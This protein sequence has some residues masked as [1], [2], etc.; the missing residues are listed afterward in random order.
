MAGE[1]GEPS[2]NYLNPAAENRLLASKVTMTIRE[3]D[4]FR[5]EV[6]GAGGW[7]D[8]LER[9][10]WRVAKDVRN[11]FVS[12]EAARTAYGVML[13]PVSFE[14]DEAATTELRRRMRGARGWTSVP[15][16]SREPT[17]HL[18]AAAEG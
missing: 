2:M 16:I 8:P 9:E 14:V 11:E 1:P 15:A 4:V 17:R 7:G 5:H 10:A 6:A 3:N 13:D 18:S 12:P